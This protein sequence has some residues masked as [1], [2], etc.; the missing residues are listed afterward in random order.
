MVLLWSPCWGVR[1]ECG[2]D[3]RDISTTTIFIGNN[4]LQL[5]QV[6]L[7]QAC[8]PD[9]GCLAAVILRPIGALDML[10]LLVR[11][12]FG[13]LGESDTVESFQFHRMLVRSRLGWDGLK[14]K[15]AF[16]GEVSWMRAPLEFKV[17]ST[18]L[19][20]IKPRTPDG[21]TGHP[22]GSV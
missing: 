22:G 9:Q 5:E 12:S 11:G 3:S 13:T 16:D 8:A 14:L 17:S 20:L 10:W 19:Y 21:T 4:R 2:T 1:I 7:S 15:V 6:G 18:P